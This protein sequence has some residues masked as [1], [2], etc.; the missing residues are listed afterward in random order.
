M[1]KKEK[2]RAQKERD[3][4]Q[5]RR[6]QTLMDVIFGVLIIQLFMI[7]PHPAEVLAGNKDPLIIFGEGHFLMFIIGIILVSIYWFQSNKTNGNL[8][9]TDGKHSFISILQM[10]FLLLYFYS[11]RLDMATHSDVLALFMQ[12]VTLALAGFCGVAGWI[13]AT[14]HA[15][16]V[17]EAVTAREAVEI[18]NS[19]L[20]EPLAAVITIP[21]AFVGVLAWNLAWL[22]ALVIGSFLKKRAKKNE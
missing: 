14:Q 12:S 20:T 8:I 4:R 9:A 15:E 19:V 3:E 18:R 17:S 13:Y 5:L 10:L 11:I 6:L 7:L 16:L 1:N 21:F 22:S 2:T